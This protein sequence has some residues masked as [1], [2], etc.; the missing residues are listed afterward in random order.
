MRYIVLK[1]KVFLQNLTWKMQEIAVAEF[2][3]SN[4]FEDAPQTR[5]IVCAFDPMLPPPPKKKRTLTLDATKMT[6]L[7]II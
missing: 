5:R 1:S 6:L 3:I 4:F 7:L 2:S